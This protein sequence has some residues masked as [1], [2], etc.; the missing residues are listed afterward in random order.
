MKH[1]PLVDLGAQYASIKKEIDAAIA[2][3]I[4]DTAFVGGKNNTYVAAFEQ[5]FSQFVGTKQCVSCANGTD[6][7]EIALE[8][9]G[10][11]ESDE[12]IVPAL[13][14]IS[15][16]EA[17]TSVGATPIFADID[18]ATYAIDPKNTEEKITPRT[19]AI[20]P[21]HLYGLPADMDAIMNIA[22]KHHLFVIEDCAQAHSAL[23]KGRHVGTF[24]DIG[25][26]SFFP[27]KN[28]GAYGDAGA[29]VMNSDELETKC[30]Q[31]ANHGQVRK[32]EHVR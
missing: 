18:R 1:I 23:Y 12:D 30:R 24:G 14:W 7:I 6:A 2:A 31:I 26:F 15:T 10:V 16:A 17:V 5:E 25:T 4:S 19:R 9:L 29:I 27:G 32:N 8:A 13:T 22:K 11:R 3:V 21:V 28:L 20:I